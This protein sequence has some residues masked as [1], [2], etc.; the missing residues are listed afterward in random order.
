[1][2]WETRGNNRYYY[3]KKRQGN[4][5]RSVYLGAGEL[6]E[7]IAALD[8]YE[9]QDRGFEQLRWHAER[10]AIDQVD[11][12]LQ[13]LA[14]LNRAVVGLAYVACDWY[15]HKRQWRKRGMAHTELTETKGSLELTRDELFNL[16]KAVDKAK[17]KKADVAKFRKVLAVDSDAWRIGGDLNRHTR[18]VLIE[19][20]AGKSV[21]IRLSLNRGVEQVKAAL[22][23]DTA[24]PLEQLLIDQV[25]LAWLRHNYIEYQYQRQQVESM[26]LALAAYWERKLSQSQSRFLRACETLARVRKTNIA[27]QLTQV[28]L[29][30][31][32]GNSAI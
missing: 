30:S 27:I 21:S 5:V 20:A 19:N 12:A 10:D 25:A 17:P 31:F 3:R 22:G 2:A 23:Y 28:N 18:E 15:Q 32:Y 6:A 29:G 24:P 8:T 9:Q 7:A 26:T 13:E 4:T 1:M 16:F 11:D 14:E